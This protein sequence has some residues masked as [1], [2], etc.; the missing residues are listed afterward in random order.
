MEGEGANS[1]SPA[2]SRDERRSILRKLVTQCHAETDDRAQQPIST[3]F[4][5]GGGVMVVTGSGGLAQWVSR[6]FVRTHCTNNFNKRKRFGELTA[7]THARKV[8]FEAF[9]SREG[10]LGA[11]WTVFVKQ[12]CLHNTVVAVVGERDTP[13]SQSA[14]RSSCRQAPSAHARS[15]QVASLP[16]PF[17]RCCCC[18]CSTLFYIVC[19][20]CCCCCRAWA[21]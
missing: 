17:C 11:I 13:R 16:L 19:C 12:R 15:S 10:T 3:R 4:F 20:C 21:V 7:P 8:R 18:C 14:P 5:P 6:S 1:C 9:V 2:G